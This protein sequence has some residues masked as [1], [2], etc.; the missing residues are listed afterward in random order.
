MFHQHFLVL[1]SCVPFSFV[2]STWLCSPSK[3]PFLLQV[4]EQ[5]HP[6]VTDFGVGLS[7][8]ELDRL[9]LSTKPQLRALKAGKSYHVKVPELSKKGQRL[10]SRHFFVPIRYETRCISY[11]RGGIFITMSVFARQTSLSGV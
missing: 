10:A 7:I 6:L 5:I 2:G 9:L 3:I 8:L 1:H 4:A 11:E